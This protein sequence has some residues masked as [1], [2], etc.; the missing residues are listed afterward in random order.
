MAAHSPS[1]NAAIVEAGI[2]GLQEAML[3]GRTDSRSLVAACLDRIDA[4]DRHG[5]CLNAVI[6]INPDAI[7]IARGLDAE[8]Q[9]GR[10]RGPL[11][12]IPVLLKDNIASAD[13]ME[14]TAG[15]LALVGA[16]APRD[17]FLVERLRAAGAVILGKTNLSEW[18]NCRSPRTVSGWSSRGGL[19]RNPYAL[20]RSASGSSSGSAVAV[21]A[22]LAVVAVGTETDGSIISPSAVNGI[23]G[24]KPTVGLVSR[25][26]VVP[27]SHSQDTPGPMARTVADA[28]ALLS[29]LAGRDA[30]D[31]A[32]L[33]A[34]GQAQ[35][36]TLCLRTDGLRGRRLGVL[37][38]HFGARNDL[39]SARIEDALKVL[40]EQGATL[41]ELPELPGEAGLGA[42]ESVVLRHELKAGLAAYLAEF[43]PGSPHRS[44][45]D[46]IAF[47]DR[48]RER[49]MPYFGQDTL[50]RAQACGGLDSAPYL[51]ALAQARRLAREDGIDRV[52]REHELDAL[53]APSASPAWL[54]DFVRG[55]FGGAGFG[56]A[57]AVAGY[58]H[59]TVPAGLVCGLPCGLSFAATAW[60]EADLIAM[61]YAYEQAS[62]ARRPPA[63]AA[64][65]P[66]PA[67][68]R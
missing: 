20:D 62:L 63:Y 35:D 39:V 18:A 26:G 49:V 68:P 56:S 54:T 16:R 4:I 58:P 41:V 36:Y 30:R 8:R 55:D 65:V 10:V 27:V 21:A 48:H 46:I 57:A 42:H 33:A 47:N 23:V 15:S 45:A 12:G 38:S 1:T 34:D 5:P 37:R 14:T 61:A 40:R 28:A 19:T 25:D 67:T 13:K 59:I 52:L 9:A 53:V 51:E 6:E 11:H 60:R 2:A 64:S 50:R 7:D 43:A 32:T 44:L 29:V 17:A 31:P 66:R 3:G 22:S 24:I